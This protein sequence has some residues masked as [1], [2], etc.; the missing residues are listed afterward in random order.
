MKRPIV[1]A[2]EL[3]VALALAAAGAWVADRFSRKSNRQAQAAERTAAATERV[4]AA[5]ELARPA[6]KRM[7]SAPSC[8]PVA[9]VCGR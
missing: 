5:L 2:I 3:L 9:M 4:A 7:S 8:P 6:P 1:F